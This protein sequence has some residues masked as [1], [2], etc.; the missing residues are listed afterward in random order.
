MQSPRASN[1]AHDEHVYYIRL[2]GTKPLP[3]VVEQV[4]EAT[5]ENPEVIECRLRE[6]QWIRAG[7]FFGADH[8]AKAQKLL[9]L[10]VRLR[11]AR[12]RVEVRRGATE[13]GAEGRDVKLGPLLLFL[14]RSGSIIVPE[15]EYIRLAR[16]VLPC[17]IYR[18][19]LEGVNPGR[20]QRKERLWIENELQVHGIGRPRNVTGSRDTGVPGGARDAREKEREGTTGQS[21]RAAGGSAT[22]ASGGAT[23]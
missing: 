3:E 9:V 6:H 18:R 21:V 4:A 2:S 8:E 12:V 7:E 14:P 11:Q 19:L 17:D 10:C 15:V 16:H 1:R 20:Y 22:T 13:L 5:G 23:A